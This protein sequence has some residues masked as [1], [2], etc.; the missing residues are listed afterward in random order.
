MP[1][2]FTSWRSSSTKTHFA[3]I[4]SHTLHI[5]K[6]YVAANWFKIGLGLLLLFIFFKKDLSFQIQ[7]RAPAPVEHPTDTGTQQPVRQEVPK[8]RREYYTDKQPAPAVV[9]T[10]TI[11]KDYLD[12]TPPLSSSGARRAEQALWA[13]SGEI[14]RAYLAR[15]RR[16]AQAEADKFGI[17]TSIILA[18][19]L[20]HSQ[21]G[22][23]ALA[24]AGHNH[25]ALPCTPDWQGE[26]HTEGGNCYRRY[27]NAWTSFRDH[28]FYLTTA[29]LAGQKRPEGQ[30]YKAWAQALEKAKFAGEKDLAAQLVRIIE[31]YRLQDAD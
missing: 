16:V 8:P 14:H 13:K 11:V 27:E 12:F 21:A 29:L 23:G 20:L 9:G 5:V 6:A 28:S 7:L 24:K 2:P 25:F 30:H 18:S 26:Q 17:P 4:N 3:M 19:A 31:H 1:A 22:E 15:F 10:E